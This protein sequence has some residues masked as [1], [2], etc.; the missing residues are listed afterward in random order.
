MQ[1]SMCIYKC[2]VYKKKKKKKKN[3]T[4]HFI[5]FQA[6]MFS[7]GSLNRILYWIELMDFF[8]RDF[9]FKKT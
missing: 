8:L 2:N 7:I 6:Q 9:I 4:Y 3:V 1:P 5:V